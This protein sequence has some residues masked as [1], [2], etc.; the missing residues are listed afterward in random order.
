ML[1][2]A[3]P[4][5]GW[6]VLGV[7]RARGRR[8]ARRRAAR[9]RAG[10][11]LAAVAAIVPLP[12]LMLLA[13]RV[14]DELLL[15]GGWSELAGGISRGISDLPGVRV[16]YRGLDDW[17]RTVIPLGGAAL[18]LLA[19]LLAFWPRRAKL[20]FPVAALLALIVLYVVPV[21]ALDFTGEFLR[22]AV[23]TLLMVAFLRLEKLRRA[24][25][26]GGRRAGR[27][28]R[29]SSRCSPRR[30]STATRR[31][32]TTRP[33]R[34]RR[35]RRSRRRSPGTTT[36]A[37]LNWPRDG[38][39]LLRVR[40]QPAR[41]L[42]GREPRRSSTA[43]CWRR[44]D[45]SATRSPSTRRRTG[46]RQALD[47]ED[48]GLDPQPAHG[49]VHHRGLRA[50][51][52]HPAAGR[53]PDARRALSSRRA[54]CAAATPTPPSVYTPRPSENQRRRA[55]VDYVAIRSTTRRSTTTLAGS[56]ARRHVRMTFPFFGADRRTAIELRA[57]RQTARPG[58]ARSA[59]A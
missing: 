32:S 20:G 50:R 39:E 9:G 42:E 45:R 28:S 15:P 11:T 22:G 4:E 56:R 51:R 29:R 57:R 59:P 17:V 10:A 1:E 30:C 44:S 21:V 34:P 36:T 13:G 52:R 37:A 7:G 12:A 25:R 8:D 46:A 3:E 48:Q 24:G 19:A 16:P 49:P 23:F 6:T 43:R 18:V 41:V 40:A 5:R 2:P 54:R 58:D 53:R 31:G 27:A 26:A 33:G 55:S 14:P 47:A 35:R 38:R